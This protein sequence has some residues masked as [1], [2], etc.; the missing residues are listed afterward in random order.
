MGTASKA[1]YN[2]SKLTGVVGTDMANVERFRSARERAAE[3]ESEELRG[4]ALCLIEELG[5]QAGCLISLVARLPNLAP[6]SRDRL[7]RIVAEIERKQGFGWYFPD[8]EKGAA[9]SER[10]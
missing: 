4:V 9:P 1:H 3:R 10:G 8:A 2:K 6:E 5:C 7:L